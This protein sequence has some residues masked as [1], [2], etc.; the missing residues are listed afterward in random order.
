MIYKKISA[1]LLSTIALSA[2]AKGTTEAKTSH[3]AAEI[4][5]PALKQQVQQLLDKTKKELIFVKGGHYMMGDFGPETLDSKL[6]YDSQ[7]D[8]KPSHK[9][10]LTDFSLS[11]TKATYADFD[12]FT[13]VTNRPK[14]G[15]LD[16]NSLRARNPNG[17]AGINWQ[18]ARDYCQW[19]GQQ[20]NLKMD[21]P[22]EAQWEYAARNRG[23]NILY[24]TNNGKFEKGINVWSY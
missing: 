19:L 12:I 22:T 13:A 5:D 14:V 11:A 10:T 8:S 23:Q 17:A 2:C 7:A 21:L 9:V 4:T 24:P 1:I 16:K 6:P 20:L 3:T 15:K 18:Q